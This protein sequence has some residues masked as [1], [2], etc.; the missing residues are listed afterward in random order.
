MSEHAPENGQSTSRQEAL[1]MPWEILIN[2][3]GFDFEPQEDGSMLLVIYP[4]MPREPGAMQLVTPAVRVRLDGDG[5]AMFK[6]RVAADGAVLP[7]IPVARS[8]PPTPG[9]AG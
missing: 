6:R 3:S 7:Q 2:I 1:R 8:M 9:S 4:M 5:W